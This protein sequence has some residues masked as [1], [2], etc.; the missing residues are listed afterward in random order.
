VKRLPSLSIF[1]RSFLMM[2][3][4]LLVS[5]A[6]GISILVVRPPTPPP[7][8]S[9]FDVMSVL[10]PDGGNFDRG[11]FPAGH[12]MGDPGRGPM[13]GG[14]MSGGFMPPGGGGDLDVGTADA[15]PAP[16]AGFDAR[17]SSRITQ[18]LSDLLHVPEDALRVYAFEV[19]DSHRPAPMRAVMGPGTIIALR[20]A[21]NRWRVT[22]VPAEAFPSMLQKELFWLLAL[23]VLV[24]LPVAWLFARALSAPIRR[25][26]DAALRLG[27]DT[28]A[29][30][31]PREGP[32]EMRQA[33]DAFNGMQGR[34]NRLV[35]ERTQ[36]IAAIAHDLRTPLTRLSFRLDGLPEPMGSKVTADIQEMKTMI[37]AALDFIRDRSLGAQ[38]QALDFR[39]LVESVADDMG[40]V[41]HDVSFEAGSAVTLEGDPVAL[42]RVVINLVD[43]G[44]K[45]GQ[46]VRLR[47]RTAG[48]DCTLEVDDDG[49]GIPEASQQ[50]VFAPFF[51]LEASRNRDTGGIGLG[52]ATVRA[53]VLDHGG[54]V[55]LRNRKQGGLRAVVTLP[56]T[57]HA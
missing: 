3:C 18:H 33:V 48:H 10:R 52:L 8:A 35:H 14:P 15:P 28:H 32:P 5:T 42:R 23:G 53:V 16:P 47:L 29:P 56:L 12:A 25:F 55:L 38:R 2:L 24:L 50:Q 49:P 13:Q 41:G 57:G 22:S 39:L 6:I 27:A 31:V 37:S 30:P 51:R 36:M 43:N 1:A 34:V 19:D 26:A 17:H 46:R 44:L 4:A 45:Y 54:A 20:E 21:D 7:M 11:P 40:D 9:V